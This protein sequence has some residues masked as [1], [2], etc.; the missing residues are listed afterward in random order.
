MFG[1]KI[2]RGYSN[3]KSTVEDKQSV[4]DTVCPLKVDVVEKFQN[5]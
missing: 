2:I 1:E 4:V 3:T 5:S